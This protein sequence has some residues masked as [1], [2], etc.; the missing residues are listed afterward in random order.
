M[1]VG[2]LGG[3]G[4]RVQF[5]EEP[6]EALVVLGD[7]VLVAEDQHVVGEEGAL[8]LDCRCCPPRGGA[9]ASVAPRTRKRTAVPD[10]TARAAARPCRAR[11]A[12]VSGAARPVDGD[13]RARARAGRAARRERAH[14]RPCRLPGRTARYRPAGTPVPGTGGDGS[15][16]GAREGPPPGPRD[17]ADG[18]PGVQR[19]I[20]LIFSMRVM[21]LSSSS[22]SKTF[23]QSSR[24]M[25]SRP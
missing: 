5:A 13:V 19:L 23:F 18:R 22:S 15:R 24:T 6:G 25:D 7:D 16:A 2:V 14:R 11:A 12:F 20:S 17:R 21:T 4:D 1:R 8:D 9:V 10:G 3:E